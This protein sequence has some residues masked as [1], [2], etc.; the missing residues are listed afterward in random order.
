MSPSGEGESGS[1]GMHTV[2]LPVT[3]NLGEEQA[4]RLRTQAPD[5]GTCFSFLWALTLLLCT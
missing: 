5:S 2:T 3:Y 4:G 1:L